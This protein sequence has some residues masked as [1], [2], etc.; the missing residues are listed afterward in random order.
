MDVG[1]AA[2]CAGVLVVVMCV[3]VVVLATAGARGSMDS[4]TF[5]AAESALLPPDAAFLASFRLEEGLPFVDVFVDDQGPVQCVVD[6]ASAFLTVATTECTHC[7]ALRGVVSARTLRS[8][9]PATSGPPTPFTLKYGSQTD[10]AERHRVSLRM[11][12]AAAAATAHGVP[13]YATHTRQQAKGFNVLGAAS[14]MRGGTALSALMPS[15]THVL[16][17]TFFTDSGK[18]FAVQPMGVRRESFALCAPLRPHGGPHAQPRYALGVTRV[19]A[20]E[21]KDAKLVSVMCDGGGGGG[22]AIAGGAHNN[23]IVD[24]GSNFTSFSPAMFTALRPHFDHNETVHIWFEGCHAAFCL[25]WPNYRF[26]GTP[27]GL[28]MANGDA[29][30]S[31][32][33]V[34][35]GTFALRGSTCVFCDDVF[36]CQQT[37]R[38]QKTD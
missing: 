34:V 17:M 24:T 21:G 26:D 23:A 3:V 29:G 13:L 12:T 9:R 8:R 28:L 22:G 4:K 32:M 10:H 15:P 14:A 33:S 25:H 11:G 6:T 2:A 27:Q 19:V 30:C 7:N 36:L 31:G 35:L 1:V 37:H 20:G 16:A 38:A 5:Q 18:M